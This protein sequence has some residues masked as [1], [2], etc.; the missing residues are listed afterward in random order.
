MVKSLLLFLIIIGWFFRF[1][2]VV[3]AYLIL[4][5]FPA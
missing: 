1:V 5:L 4:H 3:F 2:M